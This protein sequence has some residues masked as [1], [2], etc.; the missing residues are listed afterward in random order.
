MAKYILVAMNGPT[1]GG[2][3]SA[4]SKWHDEVHMPDLLAVDG[5][6]TARRFKTIRGKIP[7]HELWPY[8]AVYEI[9]TDDL[10]KI[11]EGMNKTL[12]PFHPDFDRS[13]SAHFFAMQISGDA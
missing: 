8:A 12:R 4:L 1:P 9:E 11:S 5:I 3:D 13:D 7:G 2:D 6:K 10:A